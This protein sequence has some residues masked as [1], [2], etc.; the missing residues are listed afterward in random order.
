MKEFKIYHLFW[1]RQLWN[2]SIFKDFNGDCDY[3][4][5]QVYGDHP[6]YGSD[7]LL[8]IGKAAEETFSNRM[9]GHG[10]F[11]TYPYALTR[12]HFG[13]FCEIDDINQQNWED[14][15]SIV[16]PIL[17]KSFMPPLNGTRVKSLLDSPDEN[18]LVFNW[19]NAG[20]LFQE[21][22]N[23]RSSVYYHDCEKY[24]FEGHILKDLSKKV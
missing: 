18:I 5:Y 15:I 13:Y 21:V 23:L 4:L 11:D 20:R 17:I 9:R 2:D 19:G 16:E 12:I 10:D 14:A 22:S 7:T 3:G 6:I 24:N 8:Y 1:K